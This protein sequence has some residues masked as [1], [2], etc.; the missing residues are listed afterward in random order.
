MSFGRAGSISIPLIQ[1]C[2]RHYC[3]PPEEC[4]HG[5][6]QHGHQAKPPARRCPEESEE[7]EIQSL[8]KD[9]GMFVKTIQ[10]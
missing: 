2:C 9:S 10:C 8:Q 3:K 7:E 4:D 6:I 1:K 5:N